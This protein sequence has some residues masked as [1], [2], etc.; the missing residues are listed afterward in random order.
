MTPINP[1]GYLII[2]AITSY[3]LFW[4]ISV[5]ACRK[6]KE[7]SETW[8]KWNFAIENN[9]ASTFLVVGLFCI[10]YFISKF[11]W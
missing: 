3:L 10:G 4:L 6:E 9:A 11:I 5:I 7:G 1:L 8:E 2:G